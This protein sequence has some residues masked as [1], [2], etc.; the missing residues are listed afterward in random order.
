VSDNLWEDVLPHHAVVLPILL[1]ALQDNY[2][3]AKVNE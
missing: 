3:V 1:D 2:T